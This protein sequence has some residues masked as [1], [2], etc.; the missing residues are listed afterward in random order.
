MR[1]FRNDAAIERNDNYDDNYQEP[2]YKPSGSP[3]ETAKERELNGE[4]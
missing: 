1:S 4:I 2:T 3:Q